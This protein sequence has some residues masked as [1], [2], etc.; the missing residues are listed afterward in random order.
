MTQFGVDPSKF[1]YEPVGTVQ[2]FKTNITQTVDLLIEKKEQGMNIPKVLFILDSVGNLATQKEID[3]AKS[4]NDKSDMTRAKQ[5]RSIFRILMQKM[6]PLMI[7]LLTTV[8]R[9]PVSLILKILTPS[10]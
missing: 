10:P 3:D 6:V 5:I 7:F 8:W 2:E 1:R 4:G 9:L